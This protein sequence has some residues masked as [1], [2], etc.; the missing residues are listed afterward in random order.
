MQ[1]QTLFP[2][3]WDVLYLF[4]KMPIFPDKYLLMLYKLYVCC[5]SRSLLQH[6]AT[7]YAL[8]CWTSTHCSGSTTA[9]IP[10]Q[11]VVLQGGSLTEAKSSSR[12][13]EEE[14]HCRYK[15]LDKERESALF[16]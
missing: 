8:I 16:Y 6:S 14:V 11:P 9:P 13:E 1:K 3:T 4:H 7:I 12:K 5:C 2:S 10:F 15:V